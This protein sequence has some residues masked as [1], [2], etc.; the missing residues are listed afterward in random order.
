LS[1]QGATK[2]KNKNCCKGDEKMGR[3]YGFRTD[4]PAFT[5]SRVKKLIGMQ[6]FNLGNS[7]VFDLNGEGQLL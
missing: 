1:I 6:R 4:N 2:K 3:I 7:L 5:V